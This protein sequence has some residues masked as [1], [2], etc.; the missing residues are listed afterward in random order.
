MKTSDSKGLR[1]VGCES[2]GIL[3]S[4]PMRFAVFC[5]THRG[6]GR[7][8]I[9]P[10]TPIAEACEL[11]LTIRTQYEDARLHADNLGGSLEKAFIF[12]ESGNKATQKALPIIRRAMRWCEQNDA[13]LIVNN[14]TNS[15]T[16]RAYDA[17]MREKKVASGDVR[18]E[19]PDVN[20]FRYG[21]LHLYFKQN[22]MRRRQEKERQ[23]RSERMK[24]VA[25][26]KKLGFAAERNGKA[27]DG[28]RGRRTQIAK[29]R[30]HNDFL[31]RVVASIRK[32]SPGIDPASVMKLLNEKARFDKRYAPVRSDHWTVPSFKTFMRRH[33]PDDVSQETSSGAKI[34]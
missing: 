30:A 32:T 13:V 16:W 14:L 1:S 21:A 20:D 3:T 29:A 8:R 31:I 5:W 12:E 34:G 28:E 27:E 17:L 11:S 15:Y 33:Y 26:E 7:Q 9:A 24:A 18:V 10:D 23:L 2:N 22:E 19:F 25:A 6:V 4:K